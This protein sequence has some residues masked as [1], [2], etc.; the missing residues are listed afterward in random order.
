MKAL[1]YEI[2]VRAMACD[3]QD[4]RPDVFV[5]LGN[6]LGLIISADLPFNQQN[7]IGNF[8]MLLGQVVLTYNAQQH[9]FERGTGF[10][11]DTQN[12]GTTSSQERS[13]AGVSDEQKQ[14][15]GAGTS[16]AQG[17]ISAEQ[18]ERLH[19]ELESLQA[20]VKNLEKMINGTK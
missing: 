7:V 10:I 9:Y 18:A 3:F 20:R 19:K 14:R 15:T 6:A 5:T 11:Y 8:L 12:R 16:S 2:G 4:M 1:F 17:G 13:Q